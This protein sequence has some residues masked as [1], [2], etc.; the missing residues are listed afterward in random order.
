M[1]VKS[2]RTSY[3]LFR[4]MHSLKKNHEKSLNLTIFRDRKEKV[5]FYHKTELATAASAATKTEHKTCKSR[6]AASPAVCDASLLTLSHS[7]PPRPFSLSISL[8][9][10]RLVCVC[11]YSTCIFP[12]SSFSPTSVPTLPLTHSPPFIPHYTYRFP[13]CP[14]LLTKNE[15]NTRRMETYRE[16]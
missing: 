7:L 5:S 13:P 11:V 12:S 10:S 3:F 8:Y 16:P 9:P 4:I 15:Q 2:L 14:S 1:C 6:V